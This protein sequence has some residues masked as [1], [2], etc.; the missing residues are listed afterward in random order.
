MPFNH[1]VQDCAKSF[2]CCGGCVLKLALSRIE[3][4]L[5]LANDTFCLRH[6]NISVFDR[7][8]FVFLKQSWH[9]KYSGIKITFVLLVCYIQKVWFS[10]KKSGDI[11]VVY[12]KIMIICFDSNNTM[13][14]KTHHF[15]FNSLKVVKEMFDA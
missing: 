10:L 15:P 1:V 7:C 14:S 4:I 2:E 5:K 6:R 3:N 12:D 11:V 13:L 8:K 9:I